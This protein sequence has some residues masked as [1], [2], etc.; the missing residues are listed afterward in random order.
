[1]VRTDDTGGV[2]I[3]RLE[4]GAVE[5]GDMDQNSTQLSKERDG[6]VSNGRATAAWG[7][8]MAE[9]TV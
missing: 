3:L 8:Q 1:M 7:K 9:R 4:L 2:Y 6:G 5:K